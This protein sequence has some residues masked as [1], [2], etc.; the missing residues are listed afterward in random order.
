MNNK[1]LIAAAVSGMMM[2]AVVPAFA[3]DF[4]PSHLDKSDSADKHACKGKGGCKSAKHDCKG[5]NACKGQGGC[6]S[7]KH[8]CKGKNA[9][10][11]QGGCHG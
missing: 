7:D 1:S 5:K 8:E 9:C 3:G 4:G 2:G 6:K 11:G 10:K